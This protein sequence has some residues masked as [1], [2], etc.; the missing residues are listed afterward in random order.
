M[1]NL[2]LC[3]ALL[4]VGNAFGNTIDTIKVNSKITDVTVFFSGAQIS[5]NIAL[6]TAQGK[7]VL[8]IEKLPSEIITQSIQVEGVNNCKILAVKHQLVNPSE[9]KKGTEVISLESKIESQKQKIKEIKNK[10][11]VFELEENLLL[12]NSILSKKDGG[13]TISEIKEAADFYR[14][15]LNE[16]RTAKLNLS[17]ELEDI[18]KKI[19]DLYVQLNKL[20]AEGNKIFSEILITIDCETNINTNLPVK[21]YISS[22]GWSP[23]YDF[24]VDDISKPLVIDY[25]AN[26]YQTSGENWDNV[27][28]VLSTNN[29]SLSGDKPEMVT[30]YLG[31]RNP[32]EKEFVKK[33]ECTLKGQVF[34]SKTKEPLPFANIALY[35]NNEVIIGGVTDFDGLYTIKPIPSGYYKVKISYLGYETKEVEN[36]LIQAD[37]ITYMDFDLK[38]SEVVLANVV[39]YDEPL[40][41]RDYVSSGGTITSECISKLPARSVQSVATTVRGSRSDKSEYY[42]DN[43]KISNYISNSL[44]T[45]IT[46]LEYNIEIPYNIPSDGEDYSIKIKDVCLPVNYIYNVVPKLENDVFLVAEVTNWE[47]LNLLSGNTNIYYQGT[48]T[49]QSFIDVNNTDDTLKISLGRDRNIIVQRNI[50]KEIF[51]KKIIGNN[52]KETIGYDIIIKNNKSSN[53]KIIVED[54]YPVSDR[55]S[56]E[57]EQLGASDAKLN[58]NT[59]FL[60]WVLELKPDEKKTLNYKYSVKYPQ[61]LNL[62]IK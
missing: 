56:I 58:K 22:A 25:N 20:S 59:G 54:Q 49:G 12:D 19:Q 35:K 42:T 29:P 57:I 38:V 53:I 8:A 18:N 55:K 51:D 26:V 17:N 21:Y 9:M 48:Y 60:K 1:K 36:L 31:R 47:E 6:K 30:W 34:D 39:M 41:S 45:T 28:L 14:L 61:Y 5:R 37:R 52:I 62:D 4:F 15:K 27:N 2:I 43:I 7:H 10:Y 33:G 3:L 32:Y 23:Y 13:S 50:N 24:R 44:K 46:N 16:I 11:S 40:I